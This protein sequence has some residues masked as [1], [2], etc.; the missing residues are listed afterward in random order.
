VLE[1]GAWPTGKFNV[2]SDGALVDLD[3]KPVA[4][5]VYEAGRDLSDAVMVAIT[6]QPPMQAGD[7]P[8]HGE[9]GFGGDAPPHLLVGVVTDYAALL[10]SSAGPALGGSFAGVAGV[11]LLDHGHLHFP[12]LEL[13]VLPAGWAYETWAVFDGAP[14]SLGRFGE[15]EAAHD[16]GGHDHDGA[17]ASET[18]GIAAAQHLVLSRDL[19]G[20]ALFTTIEPSPDDSPAPYSLR[21]LQADVPVD[22]KDGAEYALTNAS[23]SFPSGVATVK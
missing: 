8:Q 5:G 20:G 15:A 14:E 16:D 18:G 7:A 10:S 4:G 11:Y 19:R 6:I 9:D 21:V 23:D 17:A 13:P 22:A 2:T 3:G 12:G 1:G